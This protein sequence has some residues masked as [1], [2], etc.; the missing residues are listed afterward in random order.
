MIE[1][2]AKTQRQ[3]F[4]KSVDNVRAHEYE[5]GEAD[6]NAGVIELFGRYPA[7]GWVVNTACTALIYVIKGDGQ[8][9]APNQTT[10][11]T[12]GDQL[13]IPNNHSYAFDAQAEILY[14]ATPAWTPRQ[15]TVRDDS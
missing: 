2:I 13:L 5:F 10:D 1:K 11:F 9:L 15:V 7:E 6:I 8:L 3:T 4:D 12:A 14:T